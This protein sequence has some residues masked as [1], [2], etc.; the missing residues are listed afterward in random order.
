MVGITNSEK[1]VRGKISPQGR[2]KIKGDEL[3]KEENVK[4]VREN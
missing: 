3:R 4:N 2:I 1:R